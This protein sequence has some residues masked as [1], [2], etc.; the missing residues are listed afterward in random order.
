MRAVNQII[1]EI[2]GIADNNGHVDLSVLQNKITQFNQVLKICAAESGAKNATFPVVGASHSSPLTVN[3]AVNA[4]DP[5]VIVGRFINMWDYANDAQGARLSLQA[6]AAMAQ[7]AKTDGEKISRLEIRAINGKSNDERVYEMSER[8]QKNLAN[9]GKEQSCISSV[10]GKLEKI[11]IRSKNAFTIYR[12]LPNCPPLQCNF[13]PELL[14][15]VGR[16]IGRYVSVSGECV[17]AENANFPSRITVH[18]MKLLPD[19]KER[20]KLRDL[21]GVAPGLTGGLSSVEYVRRQRDE[22]G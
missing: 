4:E 6:R 19:E 18:E 2:A 20:V 8:L 21:Q 14:E 7:F 22:W 11:D 9:T 16:A 13:P 12:D 15:Q 3:C 17:Y 1:I 5:G 10:E